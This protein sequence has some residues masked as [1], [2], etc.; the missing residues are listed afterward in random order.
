VNPE[1]FFAVLDW[2]EHYAAD[3]ERIGGNPPSPRWDQDW[4]PRLDAA[5]AYALV[6]SKPPRRI[7]EVGSGHSTRFMARAVKDAGLATRITAID[8]EPRAKINGLDIE[9]LQSRVQDAAIPALEPND[10]LFIDSSHQN[11]A[12]S[13]V[14]LLFNKVIPFLPAGVRVHVHDIFLPD[15]YPEQWAWRKY[16][17]QAAVAALLQAGWRAD[18]SSHWVVSRRADL[19]RR[20]VLGRLPL[21]DGALESSLWLTKN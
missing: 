12:D 4:F 6:R 9:Y 5:A 15:D 3:L 2:I 13:D 14:E 1:P 17:E 20:G 11:K 10:V 19:V 16:N 18:F 7:V 8:P 21:V